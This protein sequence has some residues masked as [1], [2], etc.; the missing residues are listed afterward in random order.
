MAVTFITWM[1]GDK[2]GVRDVKKLVS[3][4]RRNMSGGHYR[5]V[6]V[7]NEKIILPDVDVVPLPDPDLTGRSCFCRLRMFDPEWQRQHGMDDRLVSLDL[8][9][10][11]TG[12]IAPLFDRQEKFLILQG[13]NAV[14][15]NPFNC[16]LMML[17][18][19]SHPEVWRDFSLEKA[20][21][22]EFHEFPDD[23]G[24]IWHK[25]PDAE[26]WVAGSSSGIYG[27]KKPGWPVNAQNNLPRDARIVAFIGSR[28]PSQFIHM[29]WV[30]NNWRIGA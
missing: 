9:L 22:M 11:V 2:Y 20:G 6:L 17:R 28:K 10:L 3:G 16:S 12:P 18:A 15:P 25:L 19:G 27:F 24:W 5:F 23:Q 4:V 7:T 13:V 29:P 1:W 30:R 8:D 14:N 21:E 26:G